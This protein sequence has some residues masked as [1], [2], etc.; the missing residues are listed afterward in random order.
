MSAMAAECTHLD[1]LR[2]T[3]LPDPRTPPSPLGA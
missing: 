2:V 3:E 1:H